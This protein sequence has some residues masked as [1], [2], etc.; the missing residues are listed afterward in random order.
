MARHVSREY[1]DLAVGDLAGRARVLATHAAGGL[2]LFQEP[3]LVD[4]Q[5][6]IVGTQRLDHIVA[7]DVAK[8]VRIPP[9]TAKNSLLPPRA[10]IPRRLGAHPPGLATLVIQ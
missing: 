6:R 3:G 5:Y 10:R 4:D 9:A 2:A 8:R 1:V 7:N